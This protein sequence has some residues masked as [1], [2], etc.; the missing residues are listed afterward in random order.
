[1]YVPVIHTHFVVRPL[2]GH[3]LSVVLIIIGSIMFFIGVVHHNIRKGVFL[4]APPGSI[5][6]AVA[7]TS[8]S[9]FGMFLVPYDTELSIAT[10][11][12]P[13]RFNLDQNTGAIVAND[14]PGYDDSRSDEGE[15]NNEKRPG[16]SRASTTR[17]GS[18][19]DPETDKETRQ[20]LLRHRQRDST[21]APLTQAG[22]EVEPFS[23]PSRSPDP[24]HQA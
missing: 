11:L 9:G 24:E 16:L 14:A 8:H 3:A 6:S 4:V 10:K 19:D 5:A 2:A 7:L 20:S 17:V 22:Y 12:S 15:E 23:P 21:L 1:M 13:L 18:N